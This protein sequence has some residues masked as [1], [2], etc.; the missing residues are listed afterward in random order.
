MDR[1]MRG[2]GR[3]CSHYAG[4]PRKRENNLARIRA[5]RVVKDCIL[6]GYIVFSVLYTP[7]GLNLFEKSCPRLWTLGD[8]HKDHR[9]LE[10]DRKIRK[11]HECKV[12][13]SRVHRYDRP[14]R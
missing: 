1:L 5:V 2:K 4:F 10:Q 12:D 8:G 14:P 13:F 3:N 11:S 9:R 7:A 6:I